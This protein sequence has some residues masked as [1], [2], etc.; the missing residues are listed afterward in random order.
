MICTSIYTKIRIFFDIFQLEGTTKFV[1]IKFFACVHR[2][3]NN[4]EIFFYYT[5]NW[6]KKQNFFSS[7]AQF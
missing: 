4:S 3:S 1:E 7:V 6:N 5:R 2:E